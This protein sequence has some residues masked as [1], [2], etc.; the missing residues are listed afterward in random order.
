MASWH[1]RFGGRPG[2]P[3]GEQQHPWHSSRLQHALR[4]LSRLPG[5][6][7]LHL[8]LQ[9]VGLRVV[10]CAGGLAA[11]AATGPSGEGPER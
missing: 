1:S 10:V 5:Q 7:A 4:R 3:H 2:G 11:A 9:D 6:A 8:R